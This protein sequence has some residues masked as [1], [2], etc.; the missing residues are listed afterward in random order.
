M[1]CS[2]QGAR[3]TRG[4]WAPSEVSWRSAWH[5]VWLP[6]GWPSRDLGPTRPK[7]QDTPSNSESGA[8]G[9]EC[10][11][12]LL[13]LRALGERLRGRSEAL[14]FPKDR[15]TPSV[16][17]TGTNSSPLPQLPGTQGRWVNPDPGQERARPRSPIE[18]GAVGLCC[19]PRHLHGQTEQIC[20]HFIFPSV[21]RSEALDDTG[22]ASRSPTV[23]HLVR[24]HG[25]LGLTIRWSQKSQRSFQ[26]G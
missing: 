9:H 6:R 2:C 20:P 25:I 19:R 3:L 23:Y 17:E 24:V 12:R 8:S 15:K 18:S 4:G 22:V 7:Q 14:F 1:G 5:D 11:G 21:I 16:S 26:K 10:P 13:S